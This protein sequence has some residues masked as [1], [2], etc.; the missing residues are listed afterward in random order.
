MVHEHHHEMP[1]GEGRFKRILFAFVFNLCFA[2]AE[3]IGGFLLNSTAILSNGL[4][5]FGDSL[6]LL[7][8]LSMERVSEKKRSRS[9]SYGYK[10]FSTLA[11]LVNCLILII[12]AVFIFSK[13]IPRLLNPVH[14]NVHG[15][16]IFAIVG[17]AINFGA[18][19]FLRKGS[20][21]NEKV[22][23]WHLMDDLLGWFA[24]LVVSIVMLIWDLH[25]LD[26]ILSIVLT[27]YFLWNV[28]QLLKQTLQ[29]FLQGVPH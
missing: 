6:S 21:L 26:P 16:L 8:S 24:V 23:T 20:S 25:I 11:A 27:L 28:L 17:L 2:I 13:A 3:F 15:M 12:G 1:Q 5:D 7:F 22:V 4:H 19:Y 9:Y 29:V 18:I 10:R 14:P